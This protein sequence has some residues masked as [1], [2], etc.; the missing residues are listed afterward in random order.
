[1]DDPFD[2]TIHE[3][4]FDASEVEHML[5]SVDRS[6]AQF[7]WKVQGL[8]ADDLH[9]RAVPTS[10]LTLGGLLKH[11]ALCEDRFVAEFLRDEPYPEPWASV[12]GSPWA[13]GWTSSLD[14]S[15]GDL[16]AVWATSVTRARAA[17]RA[18]IGDGGLDQPSTFEW[19]GR[20]PTLRRALVDLS[21]EY[22]RHVGHADLLREAID[23]LVGED[24]PQ[25]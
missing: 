25:P 24:P 9:R 5:F 7:A 6:R 8:S 18:A 3:P 13:W 12:D 10:E 11:L 15:A 1:M 14:D 2:T 16:Y 23:G 20:R 19:E 4:S 21:D 22:A 17:W